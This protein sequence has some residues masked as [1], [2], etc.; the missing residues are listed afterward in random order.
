MNVLGVRIDASTVE[1]ATSRIGAWINSRQCT[2]VCVCSVNN[3]VEAL[4]SEDYR[5]VLNRSGLNTSDGMPLVWQ[6]HHRGHDWATRVYGPDLLLS[7][8]AASTAN[9]WRHFFYGGHD[10]VAAAVA[11]RMADRFHGLRIAGTLSP[12]IARVEDLCNAEVVAQINNSGADIVW[13]GLGTPKQETWMARMR[14]RLVAPVLVGVGAAFDFHAHRVAQAPR[15]MQGRGLEW[16]FRLA[17]EP[18]RL[19]R[20]YLIGNSR[21]VWELTCQELGL[22]R[23]RL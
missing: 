16:L 20:R 18:R 3:V 1:D 8:C 4:R 19:G 10:G 17:R 13:V 14:E 7:V 21:F 5:Q 15:W 23:F 9:S 22:K 2:Y 6:V 11:A 12:P